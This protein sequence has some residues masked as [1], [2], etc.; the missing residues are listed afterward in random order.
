MKACVLGCASHDLVD[1][2]IPL[3]ALQ[4]QL[5]SPHPRFRSLYNLSVRRAHMSLEG[6][7]YH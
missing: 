2:V 4:L 7:S 1:V 6:L 3:A 5:L